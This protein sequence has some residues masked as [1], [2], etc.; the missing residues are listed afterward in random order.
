M[1]SM[2]RRVLLLS[3]WVAQASHWWET[4]VMYQIY[5]R[6][7]QDSNGD[8]TGDLKGIKSRLPYLKDL[9]VGFVWIS[10]V[11]KSP[12]RD[13]GYDISDFHDIDALFGSL[14]DFK[15]LVA[16][17]DKMGIKVLMDFVPNHS[18]NE[19]K[20]FLESKSSKTNPKRNWY[21]WHPGVEV[22]G[23][24]QPPNNW[25]SNF[26]GGAGSAWTWDSSTEEYYYHA[27]GEFQPDLNYRNPEVVEAMQ[28][29][30]RFW[31]RLGAGGFRIDAVPFLLEDMQLR[32]EAL[33]ESCAKTQ[34]AWNCM[35]H[36]YTN[37]NPQN[38]EIIQGWR[39]T[40]DEFEGRVMFGEIY[41]PLKDLMQYYG[42]PEK[43]EFNVPFN[44]EVLG[45]DFGEPNDLRQAPIVRRA[46]RAYAAAL[47]DWCHGNWVLGNH[48]N[49]RLMQRLHNDTRLATTVYNFFNLLPGTPVVYQGDEIAMRDEF[50]PYALCRDPMCLKNPETFTV[51]GRD[52]ERTPMQWSPGPQAGFSSNASTWL[53]VNSDYVTVNVETEKAQKTSPWSV[54][55]SV[56]QWRKNHSELATGKI[57]EV[58]GDFQ[59]P[60]LQKDL[61]LVKFTMGDMAAATVGNWN[62]AYSLAMDLPSL[63]KASGGSVQILFSTDPDRT[64]EVATPFVLLAGEVVVITFK[65]EILETW[66]LGEV[67]FPSKP[68][69]V[70]AKAWRSED[71]VDL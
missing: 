60:A 7:F 63:V 25:A 58:P 23:T 19:S 56:L 12:M 40:V 44:F 42:T 36:N 47:P 57:T 68:E 59:G 39:K 4:E 67:R 30:L 5:P 62:S 43:P 20:W 61:V 50:I 29:V 34:M 52:P 33:N 48:D 69:A 46:V 11:M 3:L 16:A 64:K 32:D 51:S 37:N 10:P 53:P 55:R 14:Q 21:V 17:A 27:F 28:E 54:M 65:E 31:L 6:S 38:H 26:G 45:A 49:H 70:R 71:V 1:A 13:F 35:V 15:D 18:S 24:R 66:P 41:A 22:N 9:G 2:A 8:G